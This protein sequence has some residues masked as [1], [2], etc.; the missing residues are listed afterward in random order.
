M[1][2]LKMKIKAIGSI[3]MFAYFVFI[4]KNYSFGVILHF[5]CNTDY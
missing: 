4:S 3:K 5:V 1:H 2:M